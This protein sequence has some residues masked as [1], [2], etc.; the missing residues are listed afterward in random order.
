MF[1]V[2][3]LLLSGLFEHGFEDIFEQV[4]G[5][6]AYHIMQRQSEAQ[7]GSRVDQ[8]SEAQGDHSQHGQEHE[9][10]EHEFECEKQKKELEVKIEHVLN[11]YDTD[12]NGILDHEE[13]A[14][15]KLDYQQKRAD[16]ET[17]AVL[18]R[19]DTNKDGHLSD[20]EI[21]GGF[22]KDIETARR[23][24]WE[25]MAY[26]STR[27]LAY[28][29][30]IA[31]AFRPIA[32]PALVTT[33]YLVSWMYCLCDVAWN[34][35]KAQEK[36]VDE[37]GLYRYASKRAVFQAVASEALPTLII[38]TQVHVF[39]KVFKRIGRFQRFGPSAAGLA[40]I[41]ALPFVLDRPTS[42]GVDRLFAKFW[43]E[44]RPLSREVANSGYGYGRLTE[45]F[46]LSPE[47]VRLG[48]CFV[49]TSCTGASAHFFLAPL[50][51][52]VFLTQWFQLRVI[53]DSAF[54]KS[55]SEPS[56]II[57]PQL[58][59]HGGHRATSE[60]C[61]GLARSQILKSVIIHKFQ[62]LMC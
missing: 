42:Q 38:H 22:L 2:L 46:Q 27:Y 7:G 20:A 48:G 36:G 24:G 47:A 58:L 43:P 57:K 5:K 39:L 32:H 4:G 1:H 13:V 9:E 11:K 31:E 26:K 25:T 16:P 29:S 61:A 54:P 41:P 28:S 21:Q 18:E 3:D 8:T 51:C 34:T 60:D 10:E 59:S 15:M 56:D 49:A 17:L 14:E 6:A 50:K 62:A 37:S 45:E 19:Y 53:G 33:G 35:K 44:A 30:E 40:L 23:L 55:H 52:T 12:N